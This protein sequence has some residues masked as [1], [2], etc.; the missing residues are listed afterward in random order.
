M[1]GEAKLT[2][3]TM[4][5]VEDGGIASEVRRGRMWKVWEV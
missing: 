1:A 5:E 3:L 2:E 4:L